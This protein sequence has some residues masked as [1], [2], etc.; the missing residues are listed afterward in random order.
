MTSSRKIEFAELDLIFIYSLNQNHE[1]E[2]D[3]EF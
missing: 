2:K 1:W 3:A